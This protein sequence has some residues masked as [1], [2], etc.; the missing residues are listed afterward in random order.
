MQKWKEIYKNI[1]ENLKNELYHQYSEIIIVNFSLFLTSVF[2]Y[3]YTFGIILVT[4]TRYLPR[5]Y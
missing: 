2:I 1:K 4:R 3:K 5:V